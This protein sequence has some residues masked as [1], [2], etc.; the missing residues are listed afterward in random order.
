MILGTNEYQNPVIVRAKEL[1]YETHVYGLQRGEIG[2]RTAD[3]FHPVDVCDFKKMWEE[4]EKLNPCGI[5]SI[6]SELVLHTMNYLL[7]RRGIPC[8]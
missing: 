8:N 3:F 6:C 7:R 4:V 1:G 2:E 5:V